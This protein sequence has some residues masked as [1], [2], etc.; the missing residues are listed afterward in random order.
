MARI[1]ASNRQIRSRES[2]KVLTERAICYNAAWMRDY[3]TATSSLSYEPRKI[4]SP[5]SR[6]THHASLDKQ[7]T[8]NS[9]SIPPTS[10]TRYTEINIQLQY[11]KNIKPCRTLSIRSRMPS[12]ITMITHKIMSR[13]PRMSKTRSIQV[14]LI[15]KSQ[16]FIPSPHPAQLSQHHPKLIF[17]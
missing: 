16:L 9:I 1:L 15:L 6:I 8:T 3:L 14:S 2:C 5:S 11:L 13:M 10:R 17:R 7:V 12:H 4:T